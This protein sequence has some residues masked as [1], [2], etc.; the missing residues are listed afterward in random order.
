MDNTGTT[1]SN[2]TAHSSD[3]C[4]G[5]FDLRCVIALIRHGDRTCK[6]KI[7]VKF[8]GDPPMSWPAGTD[9]RSTDEIAALGDYVATQSERCRSELS[10]FRNGLR[11]IR[12]GK[13]DLKVKIEVTDFG[14]LLKVKWGGTLTSLGELQSETAGRVF[15]HSYFPSDND[16]DI[17][18]Y[19][20]TDTRCKETALNFLKGFVGSANAF[21]QP[22]RTED[23]PDGL[24][25]LDDTGFRHSPLVE[26]IRREISAMLMNGKAIDHDL[27]SELF[28]E[29]E[30][31]QSA[32]S[33][34]SSLYKSFSSAVVE[35]RSLVED[36]V[37]TLDSPKESVDLIL[38][39]WSNLRK[40]ISRASS[41]GKWSYSGVPLAS[42]QISQIG[43]VFDNSQYDYR[44]NFD[45]LE[46]VGAGGLLS[47]IR[48]IVTLLSRVVTPLEYGLSGPEK[49]YIGATFLR[50]LIKKFRFDFR[51]CAGLPLGEDTIHVVKHEEDNN[52]T[53]LRR[54]RLYFGHHSHM[55]SLVNILKSLN[56]SDN[57]YLH[58]M[59]RLGYLSQI[60]L[61]VSSDKRSDRWRLTISL[62]EGDTLTDR[63]PE[64]FVFHE[65]ACKNFA[66]RVE[67]DDFFTQ[68]YILP[69]QISP[70]LRR[71]CSLGRVPEAESSG[72]WGLDNQG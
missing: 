19:A 1:Q 4:R 6:Q 26:E 50:P 38:S 68:I 8:N 34:L 47:R 43:D 67:L 42:I 57:S 39:R 24:G 7:S 46:E 12:S 14:W 66:S 65:I 51:V 58:Q 55:I 40:N 28:P 33:E 15:A 2:D 37:D 29:I 63:F 30:S 20:S 69:D 48:D 23:G 25:S 64:E 44:H 5:D 10:V 41:V 18:V 22:I 62:S 52:T 36:F 17:K 32:L 11:V 35:L 9:I 45:L 13:D 59:D 16:V 54:C 61:C 72:E 27:I 70:P 71:V 31:G 3:P 53:N 21:T 49:A 60:H 56:C